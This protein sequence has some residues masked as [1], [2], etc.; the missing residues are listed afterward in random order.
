MEILPLHS[1]TSVLRQTRHAAE[2]MLPEVDSM[3]QGRAVYSYGEGLRPVDRLILKILEFLFTQMRERSA[4]SSEWRGVTLA[5]ET[6]KQ[7]RRLMTD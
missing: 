2:A 7:M 5:T 1:Y 3:W 4:G 6:A